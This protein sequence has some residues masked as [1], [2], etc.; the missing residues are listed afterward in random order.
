MLV[1][2]MTELPHKHTRQ[3]LRLEP[4]ATGVAVNISMPSTIIVEGRAD[5]VCLLYHKK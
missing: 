3:L 1:F 5:T 4:N 2:G